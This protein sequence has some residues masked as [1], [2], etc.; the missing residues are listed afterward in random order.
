M[1]IRV[2]IER[3]LFCFRARKCPSICSRSKRVAVERMKVFHF[4]LISPGLGVYDIAIPGSLVQS[5]VTANAI[6]ALNRL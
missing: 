3:I 4:Q 1:N 5:L 2:S 6:T